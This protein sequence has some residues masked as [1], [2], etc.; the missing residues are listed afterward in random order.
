MGGSFRFI[1]L[2]HL[3]HNLI[4]AVH[5]HQRGKWSKTLQAEWGV[6]CECAAANSGR[7]DGNL[8]R[9]RR[10]RVGGLQ[11]KIFLAGGA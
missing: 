3:H 6:V 1:L 10:G 7:A 8:A 5:S 2:Q 11:N 4:V 9:G